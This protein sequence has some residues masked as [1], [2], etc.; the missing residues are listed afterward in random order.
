MSLTSLGVCAN[1]RGQAG[2]PSRGSGPRTQRQWG[3]TCPTHTGQ[4]GLGHQCVNIVKMNK[5]DMT[6]RPCDPDELN[7]IDLGDSATRA[8]AKVETTASGALN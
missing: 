2:R 3:R 8:K 7:R 6:Y 4:T 5:H 1:N